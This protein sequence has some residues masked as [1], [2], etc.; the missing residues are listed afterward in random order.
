MSRYVRP[1]GDAPEYTDALKAQ[2]ERLNAALQWEQNR[3]ERIGTHWDGCHLAGH[4][5]YECLL[6]ENE[7]LTAELALK[8][9]AG[10]SIFANNGEE[11]DWSHLNCPKCGGS[12]HIDDTP[13][14]VGAGKT[15]GEHVHCEN[16]GYPM[17]PTTERPYNPLNDYAVI[18]MNPTEPVKAQAGEPPRVDPNW[19][20]IKMDVSNPTTGR[21]VIPEPKK[22]SEFER[23]DMTAYKMG[24]NDCLAALNAAPKEMK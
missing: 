23:D 22:H 5:H 4:Q 14:E 9:Q 7:R 21:R 8:A 17:Y 16:C 18:S 10:E 2:V 1:S 20:N 11:R 12:G 6:C 24:W 19:V 3:S 13:Q 15:A